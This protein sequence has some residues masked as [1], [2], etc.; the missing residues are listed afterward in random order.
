MKN[1]RKK[2]L[3][4]LASIVCLIVL[5][6]MHIVNSSESKVS[7]A[8]PIEPDYKMMIEAPGINKV[9]TGPAT[10]EIGGNYAFVLKLT[11]AVT[12]EPI[13]NP[14]VRDG[15]Q[16]SPT[17]VYYFNKDDVA[18]PN[19][20]GLWVRNAGLYNGRSVDVKFVMDTMNVAPSNE[21]AT[22]Y[23]EF[24]F[25]AVDPKDR[26]KMSNYEAEKQNG[27][28]APWNDLYFMTGSSLG[29]H[30]VYYNRGD[31]IEYHY[32]FYYH[33]TQ[34][35]LKLMGSWNF[36][37]INVQKKTGISFD[38]SDFKNFYVMNNSVISYKAESGQLNMSSS[39]TTMNDPS[40]QVTELFNKEQFPMSMTYYGEDGYSG[41]MALMYSTE[42]LTRIA[43]AQPIVYGKRNSADHNAQTYT[44]LKYSILQGVADNRKENRN[45]QV[46]IETEVPE[47]YDI[48][49]VKVTEYGT[50]TDKTNLFLTSK[51]GSKL[52]LTSIDSTSDAFNGSLFDIQITAKPN[53]KFNFNLTDYGYV[54]DASNVTDNGFMLFEMGG[55]KTKT[56]Y[57]YK[58]LAKP[59]NTLDSEVVKDQSIT[60]VRYDGK[61]IGTAK[62][63]LKIPMGGNIATTY[64]NAED[65][66]VSYDV[67]T[68]NAI[69]RPVSVSYVGTP[70]DISTKK[71]GDIVEV[72]L[73]LTSA[74]GVETPITV[75]IEIT[76]TIF[77]L[78]IEHLDAETG[79]VIAT[80]SPLPSGEEGVEYTA[81]S[82][83]IE[84]YIPTAV[85]VDGVDKT[86][87]PIT[88]P[89][90]VTVKF[91]TNKK[92]TFKYTK[93]RTPVIKAEFDVSPTTVP[94]GG[95][96]T[97]TATVKN[98]AEA[99]TTWSNV[100]FKIDTPFPDKITPDVSTV[101]VNG[102]AL[103]ASKVDFD[104]L[105]KEFK[106]D[107]SDLDLDENEA[108]IKY[109]VIVAADAAVQVVNQTYTV[110]GSAGDGSK[111]SQQSNSTSLNVIRGESQ[112]NVLYRKKDENNNDVKM[113][114][115]R[116][117]ITTQ[118]DG[119]AFDV[120]PETFD[121]YVLDKIIVDG[122]ALPE[123]LPTSVKGKYGEI[124][125]IE[126]HYKG[127]LLITS[128]PTLL[129]FEMN[130]ASAKNLR[131]ESAKTDKDLVVTDTRSTKQRWYLY[132]KV[133][134]DFKTTDGSNKTLS[135]ILRYN[136]GGTTEKNFPVD[137]N[138]LLTSP[139]NFSD[140][141]YNISQTWSAKGKGFKVEIPGDYVKKLGEYRAKIVYTLSE[142]PN[143]P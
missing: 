25:F 85:L 134:E 82:Q 84:G 98:T 22:P 24:P 86:P 12:Y 128:A 109:D 115:D 1:K 32:E 136:D 140:T 71:P 100:S 75:K 55:P 95:K 143:L 14:K 110:S 13:G 18:K 35:E 132:A 107:L 62:E 114:P 30:R 31:K 6:G 57:T 87:S 94:I 29:N 19:E 103:E 56:T 26:E 137:Q 120:T 102:V 127:T 28:D 10:T 39:E 91:V 139:D 43:P 72:P 2:Y 112:L 123:P 58:G 92:V 76:Q 33:D 116:D 49:D 73:M 50:T 142:V 46:V 61:P 83:Q 47:F 36:N 4:G 59:T 68:E 122:Q 133:T 9:S 66:L 99:P 20:Y 42:S 129:D 88:D 131:V 119:T 97:Y 96:A 89:L 124:S 126:F 121:G 65:L 90:S 34:K 79:T 16:G 74:K 40:V 5:L 125:T 38:E 54:N 52:L 130:E 27:D 51:T 8:T 118:K 44:E 3:F 67:D 105:T 45:D 77:D 60:Q 63:G 11:D 117:A 41:M 64:P 48:T 138:Q 15:Y 37:N 93:L 111:A 108:V 78:D 23:P 80:T 135:G 101:K 21:N 69:D 70:P 7:A 81:T 104:P 106:I 17:K 53:S 141:K 113:D